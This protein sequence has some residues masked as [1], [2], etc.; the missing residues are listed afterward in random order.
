[1]V[2]AEPDLR[3]LVFSCFLFMSL[4]AWGGIGVL[5][6]PPPKKKAVEVVVVVVEVWRGVRLW[7]VV[8]GPSNPIGSYCYCHR[9]LRLLRLQRS[10]EVFVLE[11]FG[12]FA[13]QCQFSCSKGHIGYP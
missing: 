7:P 11:R 4:L 13:R 2:W 9:V 10:T 6:L 1:M 3:T 5:L 8:C 12:G